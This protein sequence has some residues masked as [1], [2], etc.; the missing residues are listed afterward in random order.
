[1]TLAI[2]AGGVVYFCYPTLP[3]MAKALVQNVYDVTIESNG[4]YTLHVAVSM[5]FGSGSIQFSVFPNHNVFRPLLSIVWKNLIVTA[6]KDKALADFSQTV[7]EVMFQDL[8][9]LI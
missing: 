6:V 2:L 5:T 7:D 3:V 1:M 8:S 4:T 9:V